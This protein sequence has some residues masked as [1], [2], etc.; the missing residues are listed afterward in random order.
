MQFFFPKIVDY[1]YTQKH[2]PRMCLSLRSFLGERPWGGVRFILCP[3]LA[4]GVG[5]VAGG[6]QQ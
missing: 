1:F 2:P 6:M 4:L 3:P 5:P